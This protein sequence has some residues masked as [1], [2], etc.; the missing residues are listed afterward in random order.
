M[1]GIQYTITKQ[2]K[3]KR[4]KQK[5][6]FLLLVTE[7]CNQKEKKKGMLNII[8]VRLISFGFPFLSQLVYLLLQQFWKCRPFMEMAGFVF[9]CSVCLLYLTNNGNN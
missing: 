1:A 9:A 5:Q 7:T 8:A 3:N 2:D 4:I 6:N